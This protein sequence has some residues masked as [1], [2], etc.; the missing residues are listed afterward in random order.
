MY[1]D[2]DDNG[3]TAAGS[4]LAHLLQILARIVTPCFIHDT[5][6]I[7][8]KPG[9]RSSTCSGHTL[10]WRNTSGTRPVGTFFKPFILPNHLRPLSR[11]KHINQCAR[12][13]LEAG[14]FLEDNKQ[15]NKGRSKRGK[16]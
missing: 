4:R 2:N 8:H 9:H 11:F 3:E 5:Y 6:Y 14:G 10:F 13:A 1:Q 16:K 12:N 7:F 15:A